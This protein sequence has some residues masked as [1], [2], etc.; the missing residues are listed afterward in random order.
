VHKKSL[1]FRPS[2]SSMM[3]LLPYFMHS[4]PIPADHQSFA[5]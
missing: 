2:R 1:S 3:G 4:E 5:G